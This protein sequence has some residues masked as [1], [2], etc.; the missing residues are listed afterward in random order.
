MAIENNMV[1]SIEYELREKGQDQVIDTN[2]GSHPLD[3]ITGKGHIIPG[4]ES[5]LLTMNVGDKKEVEVA[6]ADAYGEYNEEAQENVPREQFTG[7]DLQEGMSL[8][9][10]SE[11]G[12]TIQVVV[13]SF[14]E[15]EVVID[16]NH[17]LA[18]KALLFNVTVMNAR[19]CTA[20]EAMSGQV[21]RPESD[22]C[23]CGSGC[24]CH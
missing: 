7:I 8:Y 15:K 4:L 1:V 22:G 20:D 10:Q 24:G 21:A 19:E 13:K 5:E 14:D 17:P 11:D 18:G 6:P 23:G 12:Q 2:V 9:A 3:F 16:Y